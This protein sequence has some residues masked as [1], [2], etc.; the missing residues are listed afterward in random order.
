MDKQVK[1]FFFELIRLSL[2]EQYS[3][4]YIN[5]I[6]E[7]ILSKLLVFSKKHDL[8]H[9]ICHAITKLGVPCGDKIK[10]TLNREKDLAVFRFVKNEYELGQLSEVLENAKIPFIPL[11][12]AVI[13]P[14]YPEAWMRTSCDIDVLV[15]EED[16]DNAID[17]LKEKL[18]YEFKSKGEH[19]VQIYAPSGVHI[20][21]HYSLQEKETPSE[22]GKILDSVWQVA[23]NVTEYQYKMP[24]EF[25]YCYLTSHM[26]KHV[27]WGGCGIRPLVD[28][29]V[30]NKKLEFNQD[31]K[32]ELLEQGQ[33]LNFALAIEK[34]SRVWF[35]GQEIDE[36]SNLL[37]EYI[38]SG[39]VYG[40][41]ENKV[42]SRQNKR[43][44]KFTYFLSR[45]FIP[46][47]EL[48]VKYPRLEKCSILY[49]YYTV[50]RWFKPLT[51]KE[52][53]RL[54]QN[55]LNQSKQIDASLKEKTKKLFDY[56]KI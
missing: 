32:R 49:P 18:L 25:L 37:E 51:N 35:D 19:D 15:K 50:K 30:L 38:L 13:R 8:S 56:L 20:E 55:E 39:G 11:K 27:K 44:N 14:L 40:N 45:L 12:G 33:L 43:K 16:L 48:K 7:E 54:M 6:D 28:I 4:D 9:V 17:A 5:L 3:K 1:D 2:G 21:L 31:E 52:S 24:N 26:A 47:R 53:K 42:V 29:F 22:L 34:L 10:K 41:L 36:Q 23:E 46:Y